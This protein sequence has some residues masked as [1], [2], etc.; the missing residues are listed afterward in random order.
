MAATFKAVPMAN[1][2][3]SEL[4][5]YIEESYPGAC[6]LYIDEVINEEL[7][8]KYETRKKDLRAKRG[9]KYVKE[10]RL[11]HG[12]KAN[13][14]DSIATHGFQSKYNKV[15]AFGL[16]TYFSTTA[17]YSRDYSDMDGSENSYMFVCDVLVGKCTMNNG[18]REIDTVSF[19]NS[20]NNIKKPSIYVTPY[21]D[22]CIPRYL[23]AFYKNA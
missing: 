17:S 19:D 15:S 2:L 5:A 23:I 12:T 21:D 4:A 3:F 22:G 16:G 11:F 10:M 14:I 18:R 1:S 20:V 7:V 9:D 8:A 13:V 6:I